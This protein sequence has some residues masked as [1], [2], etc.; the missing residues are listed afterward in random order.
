M[1]ED[2]GG[3]VR[4][5]EQRASWDERGFFRVD[6]FAPASLCAAMLAR[7]TAIVRDPALA[8]RVRAK[9]VP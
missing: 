4:R 5:D 2:P 6:G 8:K 1:S 3:S 9:V 7:V